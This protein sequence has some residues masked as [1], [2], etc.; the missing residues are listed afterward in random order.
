MLGLV[1][2]LLIITLAVIIK[3]IRIMNNNLTDFVLE[4]LANGLIY[5]Q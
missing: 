1:I 3:N 5:N 2:G 4:V